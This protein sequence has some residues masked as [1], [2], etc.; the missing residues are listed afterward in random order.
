MPNRSVYA[1]AAPWRDNWATKEA[2]LWLAPRPA[3]ALAGGPH[4]CHG[5]CQRANKVITS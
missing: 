1:I 2:V 3:P 4:W 5:F